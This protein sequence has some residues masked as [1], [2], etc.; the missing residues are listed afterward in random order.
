MFNFPQIQNHIH[1]ASNQLHVGYLSLWH[2]WLVEQIYRFPF[3]QDHFNDAESFNFLIVLFP[4]LSSFLSLKINKCI[5]AF[6][7][8]YI[9]FYHVIATILF[10]TAS[11]T[12]IVHHN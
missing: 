4:S 8:L 7:Q 9:M 2:Q 5:C 11:H 12:E 1:R 3:S 10:V 6:F